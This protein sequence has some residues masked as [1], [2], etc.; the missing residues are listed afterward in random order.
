MK[1]YFIQRC[2]MRKNVNNSDVKGFDSAFEL[3]YMGSA[4]FE[5][6]APTKSLKAVTAIL[7]EYQLFQ[8]KLGPTIFR[9]SSTCCSYSN[10]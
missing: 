4:E 7:E 8:D 6:G 3:D 2:T 9:T 10:R 1:P 5:F